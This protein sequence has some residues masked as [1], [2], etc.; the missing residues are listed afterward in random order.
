MTAWLDP[1][2]AAL[3]RRSSPIAMFIRDDD[4]GW[5][6]SQLY[7]LLAVTE[8]RG[9]PIDLAI[10]PDAIESTLACKLW[11]L[12]ASGGLV[13][14]HQHGRRHVNHER[15]GRKSEFGASRSSMEQ[16]EDIRAGQQRLSD[17]LGESVE[18]I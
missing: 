15:A 17:L 3:D 5:R 8:R 16:R 4:G 18:P 10:I 2:R 9:V 13:A 12:T 14:A 1:I 6:D 7:R 11:R